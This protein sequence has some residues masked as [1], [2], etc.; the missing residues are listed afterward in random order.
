[1]LKTT[2]EC[3]ALGWTHR[4]ALIRAHPAAAIMT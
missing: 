4:D 3:D 2:Y 1:L